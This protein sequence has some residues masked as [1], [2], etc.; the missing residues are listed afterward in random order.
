MIS[1]SRLHSFTISFERQFY[2]IRFTSPSLSQMC[3]PLELTVSPRLII[4]TAIY[5][6][7]SSELMKQLTA[8]EIGLTFRYYVR[9]YPECQLKTHFIWVRENRV[10]FYCSKKLRK[11]FYILTSINI[12]LLVFLS[13][14]WWKTITNSVFSTFIAVF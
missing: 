2:N 11:E 8:L 14:W 5:E 1:C 9:Q 3:K 13:E 4:C 6:G 7:P 10:A 12:P